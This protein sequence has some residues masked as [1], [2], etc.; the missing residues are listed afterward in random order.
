MLSGTY[1]IWVLITI[2]ES[3]LETFQSEVK[4]SALQSSNPAFTLKRERIVQQRA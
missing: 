1:R 2:V 4:I 3:H